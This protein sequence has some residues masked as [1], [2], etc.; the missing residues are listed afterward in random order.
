M[1]EHTRGPWIYERRENGAV[2]VREA[3]GVGR[4]IAEIWHN[5]HDPVANG[6]IVA[7]SPEMA[8]ALRQAEACMSIVAPRSSAAEYRRILGVVR[9]ALNKACPAKEE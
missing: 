4:P 7:A 3:N 8:E 2:V 6:A 9:S 1:S 5:G